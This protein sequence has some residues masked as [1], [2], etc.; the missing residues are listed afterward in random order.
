MPSPTRIAIALGAAVLTIAAPV[1]VT[2]QARQSE[3]KIIV[4]ASEGSD[5]SWAGTRLREYDASPTCQAFPPG[6]HVVANQSSQR[7]LFFSDP[8][9]VM[10]V[11]PPFNFLRPGYGAHVSP[12][13][14]FK[15]G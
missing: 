8:L 7:L 11:P 13:G 12:T 15:V 4:F 9:C 2:A 10:P 6:S 14:S 5:I 3:G 1:H